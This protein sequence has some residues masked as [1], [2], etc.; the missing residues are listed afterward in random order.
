MYASPSHVVVIWFGNQS[1]QL[2]NIRVRIEL[3]YLANLP[4]TLLVLHKIYN[5]LLQ[6]IC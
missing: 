4:M 6:E 5:I 2:M 1:D 3:I